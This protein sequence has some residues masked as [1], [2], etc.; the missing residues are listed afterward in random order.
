M[1]FKTNSVEICEPETCLKVSFA[2]NTFKQFNVVSMHRQMYKMFSELVRKID[3]QGALFD[4][5]FWWSEFWK[6]IWL[7]QNLWNMEIIL[8]P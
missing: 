7:R 4:K 6:K 5:T 2:P 1:L 8:V 3:L